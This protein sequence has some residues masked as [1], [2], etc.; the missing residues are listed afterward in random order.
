MPLWTFRLP[1]CERNMPAQLGW[2]EADLATFTA[3][4]LTIAT[5]RPDG[6][7]RRGVIIWMVQVDNDI[8]VRAV[9]GPSGPWFVGARSTDRAKI[10]VGSDSWDVALQPVDSSLSDAIDAAYRQKYS[11]YSAAIVGSVLTAPAREATVRLVPIA[12]NLGTGHPM[13]TRTLGTDLTVSAIGLGCMGMTQSYGP[14]PGDR[15]AMIAFI[16]AAFDHGVTFFDTAEVYGPYHNEE[17]VGEALKPI[18]DQIVLAT[19][20]GFSFDDQGKSTGVSSRPEHIKAAV[21][22]SLKRLQTDVIDLYYQH[23]VDPNTPIEETAG[24]RRRSDR[25]RQGPPFRIVGSRRQHHPPG[26]RCL[27]GYRGPERVFDVVA[28]TRRRGP[29]DA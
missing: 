4:E 13:Q 15:N 27:P 3:D 23:R 14:P 22:G 16:R 25:S 5:H 10:T 26:P 7:Q 12:N 21:E 24:C 2:S 6:T 28:P 17:L 1:E 11:R 18:R 9:K 19:K 20:F 29:A 8:Y